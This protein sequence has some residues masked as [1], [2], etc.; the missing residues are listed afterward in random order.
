MSKESLKLMPSQAGCSIVFVASVCGL[1]RYPVQAAYSAS[2]NGAIRLVRCAARDVGPRGIHVNCVAPGIVV[3]PLARG[4]LRKI[5]MHSFCAQLPIPRPG[6]APEIARVIQSLLGQD[7]GFVTEN[8]Y[9]ETIAPSVE[10]TPH[11]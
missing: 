7:S 2:K 3:I 8:L 4:G 10:S 11:R 5:S 9:A 1:Q 6:D